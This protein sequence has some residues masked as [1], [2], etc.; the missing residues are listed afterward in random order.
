MRCEHK[1]NIGK[2]QVGGGPGWPV[3]CERCGREF[4]S[5]SDLQNGWPIVGGS[6]NGMRADPPRK[7]YGEA[8][9]AVFSDAPVVKGT[10]FYAVDT[11][12]QV[13]C[14]LGKAGTDFLSEEDG[15]RIIQCEAWK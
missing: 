1:L 2:L 10:E 12:R 5:I 9:R 15:R 8:P 3:Y 13:F 4:A 7:F 6:L 14:F 11:K